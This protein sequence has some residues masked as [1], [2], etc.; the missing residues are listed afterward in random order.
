MSGGMQYVLK[1]T[2]LNK[3]ATMEVPQITD[4]DTT[5]QDK[6]SIEIPPNNAQFNGYDSLII[7]TMVVDPKIV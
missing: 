2:I 7:K 1:D 4:C 5:G 3:G 6:V